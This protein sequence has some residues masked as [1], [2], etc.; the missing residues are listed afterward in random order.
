MDGNRLDAIL[1][2]V[3]RTHSFL[4]YVIHFQASEALHNANFE[5]VVKSTFLS[6]LLIIIIYHYWTEW[7]G[8]IQSGKQ[9]EEIQ[10]YQ[11]I[12]KVHIF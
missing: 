12:Y 6:V 7:K 11:V 9:F 1:T 3:K 4:N 5:N 8:I 10:I 2:C